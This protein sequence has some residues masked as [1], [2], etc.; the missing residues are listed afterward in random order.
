MINCFIYSWIL[1]STCSLDTHNVPDALPGIMAAT[2]NR[3]DKVPIFMEVIFQWEDRDGNKNTQ[4]CQVK[5]NKAESETDRV[6]C[7]FRNGAQGS[8]L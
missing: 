3:R 5:D 8:P 6:G 1:L 7:Y 4:I 2:V